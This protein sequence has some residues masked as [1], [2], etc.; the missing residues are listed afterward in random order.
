MDWDAYFT[1]FRPKQTSKQLLSQSQLPY[2]FD[3]SV[4]PL[5]P[6]G[7][8]VEPV[9]E[10]GA[11]ASSDSV[12]FD[13]CMPVLLAC[14][15]R[16]LKIPVADLD[17]GLSFIDNGGDSINL[18]I[19]QGELLKQLGLRATQEDLRDVPLEEL[20][21]RVQCRQPLVAKGERGTPFPLTPIQQA[22]VWGRSLTGVAAHGYLEVNVGPDFDLQMFNWSFNALR[23]RHDMLR[24]VILPDCEAEAGV[25]QQVKDGEPFSCEVIDLTSKSADDQAKTLQELRERFSHEVI[26]LGGALFRIHVTKCMGDDGEHWWRL[27]FSFDSLMLDM[28]SMRLLFAEWHALYSGASERPP[29]QLTFRDWVMWQVEQTKTQ[30]YLQAKQ[31]W[32]E[33]CKDMPGAPALPLKSCCDVR[34]PRFERLV[35]YLDQKTWNDLKAASRRRGLSSTGVLLT[36]FAEVLGHWSD[37]ADVERFLINL[38]TFERDVMM[39]SE[40]NDIIGDFTS[41]VL[42]EVSASGG[43]LDICVEGLWKQLLADLRHK[44]FDGVKVQREL[45]RVNKKSAVAPVVFTSLLNLPVGA[46]GDESVGQNFGDVAFSITQ[47]PQVLLDCK[48]FEAGERLALEWD[49]AEALEPD[50]VRAMHETFCRVLRAI[51]LPDFDFSLPLQLLSEQDLEVWR[52]LNDTQKTW[53]ACPSTLQDLLRQRLWHPND[54]VFLKS[55]AH[56]ALNLHALRRQVVRWA[57]HL[58]SH[59]SANG[60][61]AIHMPRSPGLVV[62]IYAVIE[63]G[64]AYLPLDCDQPLKRKQHILQNSNCD[65][66]VHAGDDLGFSG[67]CMRA[68]VNPTLCQTLPFKGATVGP[69]ANPKDLAYIIYT[70]GSTGSPKG[71]AVQHAAIMNR[72]AWMQDTY[73]L[74]REDVVIQKTPYSFDVSVWEFFWPLFQGSLLVVQP[75]VHAD[76]KYLLQQIGCHRV[77]IVHFVP[78]MLAH[79]LEETSPMDVNLASVKHMFCSGEALPPELVRK[80]YQV[81]PNDARVH[82]LYGPTEAAVDVTFWPCPR[83]LKST[84][85]GQ[86][87]ANMQVFILKAGR[88][89]PEGVVGELFLAGIGLAR[90]YLNNKDR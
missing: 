4:E 32:E 89:C 71:V 17:A 86:P 87:I 53:S 49:Y 7:Q 41:V 45:V 61:V 44:Q 81:L 57:R 46:D 56:G 40:M 24:V 78:S 18:P 26:E 10:G 79:F 51:A 15:S 63:A 74:G 28:F 16:V 68:D 70:S 30:S 19:I 58:T 6:I 22:Y 3:H 33:R 88:L 72:L 80:A 76:P 52:S 25:V 48:I 27:H 50:Q 90:G 13:N 21:A 42:L 20:T 35:D 37:T 83:S 75:D 1:S 2:P 34:S 11:I 39:H 8:R 77:S 43:P 65:I 69:L 14:V 60:I 47:T 66:L 82:N 59:L 73:K 84:F 64:G 85:I 5:G 38:T 12:V 36:V 54:E 23:L 29:L 55:D 31:Y 67:L 9:P 62:A